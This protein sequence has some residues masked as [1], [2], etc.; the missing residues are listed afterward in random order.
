[1]KNKI[2][3]FEFV[4]KKR[5]LQNRKKRKKN[6]FKWFVHVIEEYLSYVG[7]TI[8]KKCMSNDFMMRVFF[9]HTWG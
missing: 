4:L 7:V 8:Q 3:L 6:D 5:E 1:M 2:N 9:N